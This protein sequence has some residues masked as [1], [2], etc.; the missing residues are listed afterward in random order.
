[1]HCTERCDDLVH[2]SPEKGPGYVDFP[3]DGEQ[4]GD[5]YA[6]YLRRDLM[7]LVQHAAAKVACQ[8][9]PWDYGNGG[10]VA[11]GDMSEEDGAIPGTSQGAPGHLGATHQDG[12]DIDIAY[13]QVGTPDN[14]LRAICRENR[15]CVGPVDKLDP[16]RTALFIGTL[17]EHPGVRVVGV[18]GKAGPVIER[19]MTRLCQDGWLAAAAC[20]S[21]R[22]AYETEDTGRG[23]YYSH[24]N[25]LHV[26]IMPSMPSE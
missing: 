11:L 15:H 22:L 1:M 5:Q 10:P 18:D 20:S 2:F 21:Q 14:H 12:R 4:W 6:S 23:W 9:R 25:H 3:L 17:F 19:A 13:Y 8:A 26:S 24:F 7:M 16:W